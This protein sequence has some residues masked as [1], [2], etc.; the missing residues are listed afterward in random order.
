VDRIIRTLAKQ[1]LVAQNYRG[2]WELTEKGTEAADF[3]K[4]EEKAAEHI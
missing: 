1:K 3:V 4:A 2:N